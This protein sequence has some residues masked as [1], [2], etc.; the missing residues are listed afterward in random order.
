MLGSLV[1]AYLVLSS[2][3]VLAIAK[4]DV[5]FAVF[6]G[7]I[8]IYSAISQ[9]GYFLYPDVSDQIL[10][11]YF[12]GEALVG[13][14]AFSMLSVVAVYAGFRIIYLRVLCAPT[15]SIR[16]GSR[17]PGIVLTSFLIYIT[18]LAAGYINYAGV[19][20]YS[21]VSDVEFVAAAGLQFQI[22][23]H[24]F[25]LSPF[26]LLALYGLTRKELSAQKNGSYLS[27]LLLMALA[28]VFVTIAI[29]TGNR[30]DPLALLLGLSGYEYAK[31]YV[32]TSPLRGVKT[33][34]NPPTIRFISAIVVVMIVGLVLLTALESARG[35][36]P[37]DFSLDIPLAAQA[38]LLKDYYAPFH[39]LIGAMHHEFVQP[40]TVLWSNV[41]NSLM[42]MK[43]DVLQAFI[44]H[45]W[46]P[47]S[48]TRAASPAMFLFTEGYAFAGWLG[49]IYNGAVLATG[50][51]IWRF[52][53]RTDDPGFNALTFALAVALAATVARSQ[54][55]Y[56]VKSIYL[57]FA[58][59]MLA[60]CLYTGRYPQFLSVIIRKLLR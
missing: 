17:A 33:N 3:I 19:L 60:Y 31:R 48:V 24:L 43:V 41:A 36:A 56:F 22:F 13:P 18:S 23:W 35:T 59:S 21:S 8:V 40:A 47:D 50:L 9:V 10:K 42:F 32:G 38:V 55:A 34:V 37:P 54:S 1:V 16:T 14:V 26:A 11:M 27:L 49:F 12:G 46:A 29:T 45:H 51:A 25:K 2:F 30:T 57:F 28:C 52:F 4:K 5:F 15:I 20:S 6:V 39:V 53:S 58:P 7:M 44:V